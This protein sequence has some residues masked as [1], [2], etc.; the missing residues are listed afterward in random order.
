MSIYSGGLYGVTTV[1]TS[2]KPCCSE[3]QNYLG[4]AVL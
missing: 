1:H 4:A 3:K 2:M